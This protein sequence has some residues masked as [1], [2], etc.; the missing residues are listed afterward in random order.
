MRIRRECGV[1]PERSPGCIV[2]PDQRSGPLRAALLDVPLLV[3]P[4]LCLVAVIAGCRDQ[5]STG[6][7]GRPSSTPAVASIPGAARRVL[8]VFNRND[9]TSFQI[10]SA[11]ASR[12]GIPANRLTGIA[13]PA[14]EEV[15]QAD[16]GD[17]LENPIRERLDQAD[18][19]DSIDFIVLARGV[20]LR[21]HESGFSVDAC[22]GAMDL[23]LSKAAASDGTP[24]A[25]SGRENRVDRLSSI[26]SPYY[27]SSARFSH[28]V[29]GLY[30]VTR[31][32]GYTAGDALALIDRSLAARP[33]SGP[34]LL[35]VDPRRDR[36]GYQIVNDSMRRAALILRGRGFETT[37]DE[38]REF[39]GAPSSGFPAQPALAGYYSWGSNDGGFRL[40]VY[41]G[42]RFQAGA[43]AETAVSTSARTFRPTTGGQSLIADLLAQ[44]L[45]GAKGYVSEPTTAA[46]CAADV[47]FDRYTSGFT[48]AESFYAASPLCRWKD[49]VVGDPLCAPYAR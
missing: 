38:T 7:A 42:L 13:A 34:F 44:G 8:V 20:P 30:L 1:W 29:F 18:L 27:R 46:L 19:R 5:G 33:V 32:D 49:V 16:Y 25:K 12:R 24:S 35:D 36:P 17:D 21:V 3:V 4:L 37:L 41:H 9:S 2:R 22:L 23:P 31:L 40:D 15:S 11:Y 39:V 48:L 43:L 6:S 47:L 28:A 45:T 26:P 14:L 10:A